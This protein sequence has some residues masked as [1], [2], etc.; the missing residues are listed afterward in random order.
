MDV[1]RSAS[2]LFSL[3][4]LDAFHDDAAGDDGVGGCDGWND[5]AS[6]RLDVEPTLLSDAENL[7]KIYSAN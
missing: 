3:N 6:H 5:V 2:I 1:Y 7:N 4:D